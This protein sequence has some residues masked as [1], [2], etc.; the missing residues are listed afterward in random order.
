[1][2]DWETT[3]VMGFVYSLI[4]IIVVAIVCIG[5]ALL[6]KKSMTRFS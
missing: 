4:A 2:Q 3:V 1:M 5:L 6:L